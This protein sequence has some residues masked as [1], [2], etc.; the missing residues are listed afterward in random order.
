MSKKLKTIV[1]LAVLCSSFSLA[2]A[3]FADPDNGL[4]VGGNYGG[5][6]SRGGDFDDDRYLWEAVVGWQIIPYVALEANYIDFAKYGN[7][8]ASA[9]VDGY[10]AAVVGRWPLTE[11][12]SIYAKGGM[13]WADAD[14][15]VL[16]VERSQSDE[17]A[18]YGVGAAFH[19]TPLLGITAEY[20]RFEVDYDRDRFP[21]APRRSDTDLDTLTV[22]VRFNF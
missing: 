2:P 9:N 1:S 17:N 7:S 3:G 4:Y 20:K 12:F 21:V 22:G 14:V 13:F 18:F 5:F 16:G 6:K 11:S 15:K 8:A 19:I 10:G